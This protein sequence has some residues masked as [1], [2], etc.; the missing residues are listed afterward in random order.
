MPDNS[1]V[2][3]QLHRALEAAGL[4]ILGVSIGQLDDKATWKVHYQP[5]AS[6]AQRAQGAQVVTSFDAS[7]SEVKSA[8]EAER[9]AAVVTPALRAF[10]LFWFRK[11]NGRD[12]SPSERATDLVALRQAYSDVEAGR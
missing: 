10:Y 8:D 1:N 4:P 11:T 5:S 3:R 6:A 12:P 7:S 2:A 9:V